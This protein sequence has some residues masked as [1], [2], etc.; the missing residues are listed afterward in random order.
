MKLETKVTEMDIFTPI[1]YTYVTDTTGPKN[2]WDCFSVVVT[3]T[4]GHLFWLC[5]ALIH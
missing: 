1:V 4:K 3:G 2:C 5:D